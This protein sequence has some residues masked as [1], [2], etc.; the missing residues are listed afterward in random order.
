MQ[1]VPVT[2]L[3]KDCGLKAL[4]VGL[5]NL[6]LGKHVNQLSGSTL[7]HSW[8][9]TSWKAAGSIPNGVTGIIH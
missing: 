6:L 9:A 1:L 8:F 4:S 5:I 7:W 2:R 3:S